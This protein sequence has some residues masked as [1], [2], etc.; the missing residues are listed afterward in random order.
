VSCSPCLAVHLKLS[1]LFFLHASDRYSVNMHISKFLQRKL[2]QNWSIRCGGWNGFSRSLTSEDQ[3]FPFI[4]SMKEYITRTVLLDASC[5]A[6]C[7]PADRISYLPIDGQKNCAMLFVCGAKLRDPSTLT[8]RRRA[9]C[10]SKACVL[11]TR[12]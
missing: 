3:R 12:S 9:S 4:D 11:F 10:P 2:N 6:F 1:V 8:P 7:R 5:H